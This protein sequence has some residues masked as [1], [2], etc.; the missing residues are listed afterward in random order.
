MF[1]IKPKREPDVKQEVTRETLPGIVKDSLS[2]WI[3]DF[4]ET[5]SYEFV[6]N[7]FWKWLNAKPKELEEASQELKLAYDNFKHLCDNNPEKRERYNQKRLEA[8]RESDLN[9]LFWKQIYT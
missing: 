5:P 9:R 2:P 7:A 1:K 3:Q 6:I 8:Q 4:V